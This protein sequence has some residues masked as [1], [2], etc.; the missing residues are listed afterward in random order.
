MGSGWWGA[1][2]GS[3]SLFFGSTEVIGERLSAVRPNKAVAFFL[4]R[5][6]RART[7][8][9]TQHSPFLLAL[10]GFRCL[11][12]RRRAQPRPVPGRADACRA[13]VPCESCA[14]HP[15]PRRHG[16]R[17]HQVRSVG[18][19]CGQRECEE[20]EKKGRETVVSSPPPTR[21]HP[22]LQTR[23]GGPLGRRHRPRLA[24]STPRSSSTATLTR[25][26]SRPSPSAT[27]ASTAS[28]TTSRSPFTPTPCATR[29][30]CPTFSGF[31]IG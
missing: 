27:R 14:L 10:H 1:R 7:R 19:E 18:G 15:P 11:R 28:R 2:A 9:G 12:P 31:T 29:R 3:P 25:A 13:T 6:I 26:T 24:P 17:G 30:A 5:S 4:L 22:S 16:A 20:R 23:T 21:L 8:G